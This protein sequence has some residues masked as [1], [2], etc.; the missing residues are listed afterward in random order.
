M[1][2]PDEDLWIDEWNDPV[3]VAAAL[4]HAGE[5]DPDVFVPPAAA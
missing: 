2:D 5:F 1:F 3:L 4:A